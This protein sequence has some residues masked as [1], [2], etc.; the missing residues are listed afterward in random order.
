MNAPNT[1]H[2]DDDSRWHLD[3]RVPIALIVAL[4][5]HLMSSIWFAGQFVQRQEN[6]ERR[7]SLIEQQN[8]SGRLASLESQVSDVKTGVTKIDGKLDRI[9]EARKP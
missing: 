8:I 6:Q 3:K 2:V 5:V 7:L 4:A 1:P 9:I